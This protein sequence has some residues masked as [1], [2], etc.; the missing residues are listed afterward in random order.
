MGPP[1]P[2]IFSRMRLTKSGSH[3]NPGLN[4]FRLRL[5]SQRMSETGREF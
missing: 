3:A 2:P 1:Q 5:Q 4:E